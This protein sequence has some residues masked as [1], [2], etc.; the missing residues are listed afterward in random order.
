MVH[1]TEPVRELEIKYDDNGHPSWC[2]FPSHKNV[3][4]RGACD[5]PPHLPG[6]IILVHGV[7]ST[8]E[9]YQKA[10][11]ALCAGLNK[12]LGLEGTNFELKANIY[13]GDDKIELD[14][15]G[16]EKR[17]PMSPLVERKLVTDNGR[18]PVIRFYWGY[19]SPLGDEDKFVIPL[20][21]IKGDDYHQMKRDGVPLYDILKKR[22]LYMGRR[23]FSKWHE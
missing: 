22:S 6:L 13:S 23:S 4:V 21:S 2:S 1:K 11:S 15:K 18:S 7:N 5:V 3:Q 17:T 10:E 12:R 14:E 8:G 16:A 19:S 9:W 20:V